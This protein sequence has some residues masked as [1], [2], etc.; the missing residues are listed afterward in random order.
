P[1]VKPVLADLNYNACSGTFPTPPTP[2]T[3]DNCSANPIFGTTPVQF[4]ITNFGTT[5]VPWTFSDGNGN[6]VV[7]TQKVTLTGLT[8]LG[9][10]SPISGTNGTCDSPLRT[11]NQGSVNPIKF[12][13]QCG[14]TAIT[15]GTPPE[16]KIQAY[17]TK[18]CMA[19]VE[20]VDTN[21]TYQ[22]VWH[23]NWDT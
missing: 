17:S 14:S 5:L 2:Q 15:G 16:V 7:V 6:S 23:Y 1:P 4:P 22:N 11:I 21:A 19:G 8:F 13:L 3:T 9:F 20:L 10:Y 12:D 18:P